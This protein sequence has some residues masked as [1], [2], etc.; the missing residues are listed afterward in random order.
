[1]NGRAPGRKEVQPDARSVPVVLEEPRNATVADQAFQEGAQDVVDPDLRHRM[2][3]EAA[4]G[5]YVQ[6]G[7]ADGFDVDDWMAAE[8]Q[9]DHL[10]VNRPRERR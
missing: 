9:V 6:R 8:A 10:L 2:I 7:Y 3:S 4:Y 1:M 5:L